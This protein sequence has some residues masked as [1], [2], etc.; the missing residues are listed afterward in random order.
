MKVG[1]IVCFDH[2]HSR[3]KGVIVKFLDNC[4]VVRLVGRLENEGHS[5]CMNDGNDMAYWNV[6]YYNLSTTDNRLWNGKY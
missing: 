5:A 2:I 3:G 1:D 6:G 4:A